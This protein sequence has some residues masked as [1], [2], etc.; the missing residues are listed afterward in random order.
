MFY[1]IDCSSHALLVPFPWKLGAWES[2]S[3]QLKTCIQ[4]PQLIRIGQ[5]PTPFIRSKVMQVRHD[6]VRMK[7]WYAIVKLPEIMAVTCPKWLVNSVSSS[8]FPSTYAF[9]TTFLKI[10]IAVWKN[11]FAFGSFTFINITA[12]PNAP[13]KAVI[14]WAA[15]NYKLHKLHGYFAYYASRT[16]LKSE[17]T[18]TVH[19]VKKIVE[20][21]EYFVLFF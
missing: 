4:K 19:V 2:I 7:W 15:V 8:V 9:L 16:Q 17:S 1:G 13:S 11:S 10:G 20:D 12:F 14:T 21:G 6:R 3:T 18:R 5:N